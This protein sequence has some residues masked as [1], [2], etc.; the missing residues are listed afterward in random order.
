VSHSL[1]TYY[2]RGAGER[3]VLTAAQLGDRAAAVAALLGTGCGVGPGRSVAVRMA[4]HWRT[5]AVLL[6]SWAAGAEVS[7]Q[8]WAT[9]GLG[10]AWPATDVAFVSAARARSFL[11]EPPDAGYWFVTGLPPG[12]EVPRGY[13]DLEAE[14]RPYADAA[15]PRV[16]IG[17]GEMAMNGST[18]GQW[19]AIAAGI[20]AA[21]GI[22]TGDRVLVRAEASEQPAGWLLAPL[23]AGASIVLCAGFDDDG[24]D[25]I[26]AAEGVTV[27]G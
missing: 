23:V 9:A 18:Y 12:D 5:A 19:R 17:A 13:Q 20:A 26:A 15:P 22:T 27:R 11:E 21:G 25:E 3:T 8:G 6:G 4:P 14:L 16:E 7:Y 24:L 1:L 2:D 10:G